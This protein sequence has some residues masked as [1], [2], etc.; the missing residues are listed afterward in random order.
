MTYIYAEPKGIGNPIPFERVSN[1]IINIQHKFKVSVGEN[2]YYKNAYV[3]W[4]KG[5]SRIICGKSVKINMGDTT[6]TKVANFNVKIEFKGTLNEQL[7]DLYFIRALTLNEEL[8]IDKHSIPYGNFKFDDKGH[9][10]K[11]I[12]DLEYLKQCLEYYGVKTDFD[13]ES[14]TE[15][16]NFKLSLLMD[17]KPSIIKYNINLIESGIL[18]MGIANI[19]ILLMVEENIKEGCYKLKSFFANTWDVVYALPE[20]TEHILMS[21]FLILDKEGLLADNIDSQKIIKDIKRNHTQNNNSGYVNTF[22]LEAIK[23]YDKYS[24]Q[25]MELRYIIEN[26]SKWLYDQSKEDYSFL[27]LAQVKYRLSKLDKIDIERIIDISSFNKD[28]IEMLAGTSILLDKKEEAESLIEK[29][30][31]EQ[32]ESFMSYPI[33]NLLDNKLYNTNKIDKD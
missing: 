4:E 1:A 24:P 21:Q 5:L 9:L 11:R 31:S 14:I 17:K 26:L 28:N 32:K 33:Y 18:R 8:I 20:T 15:E 16:D 29:M 19:T 30:E 7:N 27:N 3:Q 12:S 25:Q 2:T 23:A 22:L 6:N 10:Y 13:L